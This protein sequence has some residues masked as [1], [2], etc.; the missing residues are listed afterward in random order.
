MFNNF[1][2]AESAWAPVY[3]ALNQHKQPTPG[4]FQLIPFFGVFFFFLIWGWE[5]SFQLLYL[6]DFVFG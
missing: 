3:F 5:L 1:S 4:Y 6:E 2:A